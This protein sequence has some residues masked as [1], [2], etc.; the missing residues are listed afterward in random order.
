[1]IPYRFKPNAMPRFKLISFALISL[2]IF[3]PSGFIQAQ[4]NQVFILSPYGIPFDLHLDGVCQTKAATTSVQVPDL[5]KVKY[6]LKLQFKARY[7]FD[8][9]KT[10][11]YLTENGV[12]ANRRDFYFQLVPYV[13]GGY[14]LQL[15]AIV[16]TGT[17][18]TY[19]QLPL[20]PVYSGQSPVYP[21]A[22][23][24]YPGNTTVYPSAIP[25]YPAHAPMYGTPFIPMRE[26][27]FEK[28]KKSVRFRALDEDRLEV[29]R[30]IAAAQYLTS[31]QVCEMTRI[32]SFDKTKLAF[33]KFAYDRTLDKGN[34]YLVNEAFSFRST[35]EQLSAYLSNRL[36]GG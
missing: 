28:A 14:T 7:D 35:R 31:Q 1:M 24:A 27:E 5:D 4:N 21:G 9:L 33:A 29:A 26:E 10:T 20:S 13:S 15:T 18:Y 22:I 34:Y 32:F 12:H 3:L 11:L 30:Q 19:G 25:V 36:A 6:A 2:A 17:A 8:D 16:P 23:P